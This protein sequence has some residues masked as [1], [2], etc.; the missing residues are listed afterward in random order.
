MIAERIELLYTRIAGKV[1]GQNLITL[2][3][4]FLASRL[5]IYTINPQNVMYE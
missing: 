3:G 2:A 1:V 5:F 4:M